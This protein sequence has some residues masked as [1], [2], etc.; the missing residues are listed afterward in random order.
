M[1]GVFAALLGGVIL[2]MLGARWLVTG[3]SSLARR[4]G[5]PE[6]VVGLTVVAFGTSAPELIVS[7]VAALTANPEV[8][9]ANVIGSNIFNVFVILGVAAII[10]PIPAHHTT[11]WRE[12]PLAVGAGVL[13]VVFLGDSIL[14]GSDV[15]RLTRIEGLFL[16]A[17]FCGF[18]AYALHSSGRDATPTGATPGGGE[19][20][21]ARVPAPPPGTLGVPTAIAAAVAGIA[22]LG[23]GARLFVDGAVSLA[24][25]LGV[26]TWLI[27]VTVV[28]A[29]TSLPELLTTVV[30]ARRGQ[31]DIALGN[32]VG[33]NL[34]NTFCILGTAGTIQPVEIAAGQ[35]LVDG[36]VALAGVVLLFLAMFTG[37]RR[38]L[39]RWEG[40]VFLLL[41]VAYVGYQI[42]TGVGS[43]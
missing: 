19:E 10:V 40:W 7:V 31:T 29:G 21:V 27:G 4:L 37:R 43:A 30:A 36:A 3:A 20:G 22:G 26:P 17:L 13:Y 23:L 28:A 41:F 5:I 12:I 6:L 18:I 35:T 11:A 24:T 1:I 25:I 2:L 15:E 42:A 32:V 34:F 38:V 39:D 8:A 9:V 14:F 33:S 16:L